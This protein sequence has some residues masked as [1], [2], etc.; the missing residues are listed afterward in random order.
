[1]LIST[2]FH[3]SINHIFLDVGHENPLI[4]VLLLWVQ[5]L[6]I[7]ANVNLSDLVSDSRLVVK[8]NN[9]WMHAQT[10]QE[11]QN[12]YEAVL[13]VVSSWPDQSHADSGQR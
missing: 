9:I 8:N 1:M 13:K 2:Y 6:R 12:A 5:L 7:R 4:R 11:L 10:T 3:V